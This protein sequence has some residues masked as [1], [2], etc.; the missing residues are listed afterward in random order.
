MTLLALVPACGRI[1]FFDTT[2]GGSRTADTTTDTIP[3]D[4]AVDAIPDL[5]VRYPMDDDPSTTQMLAATDP[6]LD[7]TCTVG[8]CPTSVA[9]HIGGAVMF[10]GVADVVILPTSNLITAAPYTIS[11]WMLATAG[12]GDDSLVSKAFDDA[13]NYDVANIGIIQGATGQLLYETSVAGGSYDILYSPT[14]ARGAWHH[15]AATWDGTDKTLYLDGNVVALLT[16]TTTTSIELVQVGAD[17]D[18][19]LTAHPFTG[20]L[21]DLRFYSRALTQTEV[22]LLAAQ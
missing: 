10:D 20:A 21:D 4:S 6:V 19:G 1:G 7:G 9:G 13:T 22:E 3:L 11:I 5:V 2:D 15:V 12:S 14:D 17:R 16:A 18:F 8:Q